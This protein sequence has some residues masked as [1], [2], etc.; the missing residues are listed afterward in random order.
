MRV[1][2]SSYPFERTVT[3]LEISWLTLSSEIFWVLLFSSSASSLPHSPNHGPT[4]NEVQWSSLTIR[5]NSCY[6]VNQPNSHSVWKGT[7]NRLLESVSCVRKSSSLLY[8]CNYSRTECKS[9]GTTHSGFIT[10]SVCFYRP[11]PH[12]TDTQSKTVNCVVLMQR[13]SFIL[14]FLC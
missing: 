14:L 13:F 10:W 5:W 4:L 12:N 6:Q 1:L 7:V 2:S 3:N 8:C 11:T 9:F